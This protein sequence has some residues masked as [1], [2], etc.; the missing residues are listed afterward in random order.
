M[1]DVHDSGGANRDVPGGPAGAGDRG[2]PW[3]RSA[4]FAERLARSLVRDAALAQDVAQDAMVA[5]VQQSSSRDGNPGRGAPPGQGWLS[6]VIRR[7]AGRA[8]RERRDRPVRE[9]RAGRS[10]AS[11]HEQRTAERLALQRQLVAAVEGLAEPYRTVVTLRHLD[12]LSPRAIARRLGKNADTV[13]QQLHRGLAM[14]RTRLDSSFGDR[15]QWLAAIAASGLGGVGLVPAAVMAVAMKKTMA[16]A[17][18][19]VAGAVA[20]WAISDGGEP[21]TVPAGG[22]DGSDPVT[23]QAAS[24]ATKRSAPAVD[25][26]AA[27]AERTELALHV[28]VVDHE[29]RPRAGVEVHCWEVGER[30]TLPVLLTDRNGRVEFPARDGAGHVLVVAEGRPPQLEDLPQLRGEHRI[31][32]LLGR[33]VAG[34]ML[35][36]GE[37]AAPGV[38]I[39]LNTTGSRPAGELPSSIDKVFKNYFGQCFATTRHGG[40]FAFVGLA[41]DWRGSIVMPS[42]H[43]LLPPPGEV[44]TDGNQKWLKIDRPH[45][46][47]VVRTTQLPT[48]AG[49]VVWDDDGS[50]VR[51]ALLHGYAKFE[52]GTTAPMI[53]FEADS[54]GRFALGFP[55]SSSALYTQWC[56]PQRRPAFE[57]AWV[58][59][60]SIPGAV[61]SARVDL[62]AADLPATDVEIRVARAQ[63][64]WFVV[65]DSA[66]A[67][68]AGARVSVA[69]SAPSNAA[70]LGWFRGPLAKA[71]VGAPGHAVVPAEPSGGDGTSSQ[72]FEFELQKTNGL[73]IRVHDGAGNRPKVEGVTIESNGDLFFG[74]HLQTSLH[75]MFGG[76]HANCS[77]GGQ[78]LPDGG[79]DWNEWRC[80]LSLDD[81]GHAELHS[82]VPG[83]ECELIVKDRLQQ[84]L[85]RVSFTTPDAGA[86][87]E[88]EAIVR[89]QPRRIHGRVFD[90]DGVPLAGA[91]VAL[92]VERNSTGATTG[93]DGDFVFDDVYSDVP[94]RLVVRAQGLVAVERD[95]L[96][97]ADDVRPHDFRLERGRT[98]DVRVVD[99]ADRPVPVR[100]QFVERVSRNNSAQRLGPGHFR[101]TNLP[102]VA[103][104]AVELG[105]ERFE[106]RHDTTQPEVVLR[107]PTPARVLVERPVG[108]ADPED[109]YLAVELRRLDG[110][111]ADALRMSLSD[112]DDDDDDAELV[113]P[114][115]YR[116]EVVARDR[117]RTQSPNVWHRRA[118]GI[119]TT[120]ALS[121]G[122]L[123]R[124]TFDR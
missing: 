40:H 89:Q 71:Y 1:A 62:V 22:G 94:L 98:V 97:P 27:T 18:A 113:V 2:A 82:L 25:R 32:Q 72:P 61:G 24:Q 80:F 38:R 39:G 49:R 4:A 117:D 111:E 55:P 123:T 83:R 65:R 86:R 50:P 37:V 87:A 13:R 30:A 64:E 9:A 14:L 12:G 51:N 90:P 74:D 42:T 43:W 47:L 52:G 7:L 78:S 54:E 26:T 104:F 48:I 116:V 41:E 109:G 115:R 8:L 69:S 121:A 112:D 93:P 110:D 63:Q 105:K 124:V 57:S 95:G 120:V 100:V 10:E 85:M 21:V 77:K 68:I 46:D 33:R 58:A 107:V 114:G 76:S 122:E 15:Q 70:G 99:A 66:G 36:D 28:T 16:V 60:D 19:L 29:D 81:A 45:P 79:V 20:W 35:V 34:T 56:D 119:E 59:A 75:R 17:A 101:W 44:T 67:L 118:L 31:V 91:R 6:T 88:V 103:T 84:E 5:A 3:D 102:A 53:G 73:V 23:T 108:V 96:L 92:H 11:D 106:V